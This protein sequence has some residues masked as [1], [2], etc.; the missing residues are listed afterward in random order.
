MLPSLL[1]VYRVVVML[2][3]GVVLAMLMVAPTS[4]EVKST[5]VCLRFLYPRLR[6]FQLLF[7]DRSLPSRPPS[8][9]RIQLSLWWSCCG[10]VAVV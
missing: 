3:I 5:C 6:F 8:L 9:I 4:V 1:V 10:V 2:L 7:V